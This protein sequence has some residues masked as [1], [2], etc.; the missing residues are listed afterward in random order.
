MANLIE[1][2]QLEIN[3]VRK[4]IAVYEDIPTGQF[5]VSIM[6]SEIEVSENAIAT[7]NTIAMIRELKSLRE[8]KI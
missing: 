3:R 5:A 4:I 7:G 2:L 1:G 8:F 6:K